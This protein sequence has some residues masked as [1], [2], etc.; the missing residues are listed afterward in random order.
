MAHGS[1]VPF[2]QLP[3][4]IL[5]LIFE[6]SC[7]DNLIQEY[8]WPS[9]RLSLPAIAYLPAL[10]ISAVCT[11]WRSLALASPG[12]WSQF[13]LEI[14]P[15]E[16]TT[17]DTQSGFIST[18]QFYLTRSADSPLQIDLET[19]GR[20]HGPRN[21]LTLDL[22][23]AHT[24]R[25]KRFSYTGDY[26][27]GRCEGLSEH[28]SF[29]V[30]DQLA[31]RGRE[32]YIQVTDLDCF[33]HAPKLFAVSTDCLYPA[34]SDLRW[35]QLTSLDVLEARDENITLLSQC[36]GLAVL[37]LRSGSTVSFGSSSISLAS[38]KSFTFVLT[39][40]RKSSLE[41][42][43]S[44]FAFPSLTELMLYSEYNSNAN[45]IWPL[46][47]FATFISRSSCILT[48]LSLSNVII[49]DLNLIAAL[50]LLPSLANLS[51]NNLLDPTGGS[52]LTSH[53]VSSMHGLSAAPL[54]PKLQSLSI[55]L[56]RTSFDDAAFIG[57]ISSRW[58]PDPATGLDCLR[59][60]VFHFLD[61]ELDV[62]LYEPLW[63]LDR[64]GMRVVITGKD[65]NCNGP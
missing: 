23:L 25:W 12:L 30:L 26:D 8:P 3:N 58:M 27:L 48:T 52:P 41:K 24:T 61:R 11:R 34:E 5:Y 9:E 29:P 21:P 47:A 51:T 16:K 62:E 35:E 38:L 19:Q 31:L 57:M 40:K 18:L 15:I 13:R 28:P 1:T 53:F 50:R 65:N 22:I 17:V 33:E 55:K 60:L 14:A 63:R 2:E 54:L 32:M 20:G 7:T 59:S 44:S 37:K 64:M 45:I 43:L 46:D 10:A 4:E 49:S 42:I 36:T 39:R 6:S 56:L